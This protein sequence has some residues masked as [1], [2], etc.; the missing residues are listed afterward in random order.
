MK[1]IIFLICFLTA[2]VV[3]GQNT[4]RLSNHIDLSMYNLDVDTVTANYLI[5][6]DIN[7]GAD[8]G[9]IGIR[10]NHIWGD[11]IHAN[12]FTNTDF[13]LGSTASD[14]TVNADTVK[15]DAVYIGSVLDFTGNVSGSIFY[16]TTFTGALTGDVTGNVT[17][18]NWTGALSISG[19]AT[20]GDAVTDEHAFNGRLASGYFQS[21]SDIS[22]L[23]RQHIISGSAKLTGVNPF[24][25]KTQMQGGFFS[26]QIDTSSTAL[27]T[28]V[29]VYG[30]ESKATLDRDCSDATSL[31]IGALNKVSIRKTTVFAGTA[32]G[33][34]SFL[35]R[36]NTSITAQGYN[37]YAE[38][39]ASGFTA[40]SILGTKANTWDYGINFN[41]ATFNTADLILMNGETIDN[42]TDGQIT[43]TGDLEVTGNVTGVGFYGNVI[44]TITGDITGNVTGNLLGNVTGDVTG[45]VTGNLTGNITGD[46]T[47]N[48]YGTHYGDVGSAGT[49]YD[50]YADTVYGCSD[51]VIKAG[52]NLNIQ[53]SVA[54]AFW[55]GN[56][57]G[58]SHIT[59]FDTIASTSYLS[60]GTLKTISG[61]VTGLVSLTD[62]TASWLTSHLTGFDTIAS[63]SYLSDGTWK[64]IAGVQTGLVSLTDGTSAWVTDH[65]TGFDTIA[66]T[67]YITD[68]NFKTVAGVI[69]GVVSITDGTASWVTNHLTGFDTIASTSYLT[70]G[71]F[72]TKA[73]VLSG[74]VSI[75]DGSA[76]WITNHLTGFDTIASTS[77]L[78]DG[79]FK[80]KA[81]AVTGVTTLTGG[82]L[83]ATDSVCTPVIWLGDK[84]F[85]NRLDTLCVVHGT[86]T[87]RIMPTR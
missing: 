71:T 35:G 6:P 41:L 17:G 25:G 83:T 84:K 20:L 31:M 19:N 85:I 36:D 29:S 3:S 4:H 82:E 26:I 80:A 16:G 7:G 73:G 60:D 69:S 51:I 45:N 72:K 15:G 42:L 39:T 48:S 10:F 8:I 53:D 55:K 54:A 9:T 30:S 65:L 46:L 2:F 32:I 56:L 1:K 79:T 87:L 76:Q 50:I 27:S 49:C 38:M 74:V 28:A 86:D 21:M 12:V 43:I 66:S 47:G 67:H 77:Y 18:T 11:T 37:Y 22:V 81:G 78:T 68:G 40:S 62:G 24:N 5:W 57:V 64:S 13:V 63:T 14:L 58:N 44:G 59:G 33:T 52:S 70:D 23:T 75:T 34:Y 61:V